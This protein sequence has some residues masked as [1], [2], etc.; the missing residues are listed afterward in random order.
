MNALTVMVIC[1]IHPV[2]HRLNLADVTAT[3][4]KLQQQRRFQGESSRIE[5]GKVLIEV[6][7]S[8]QTDEEVGE[9]QE[10]LKDGQTDDGADGVVLTRK[11]D[12][13]VREA[14]SGGDSECRN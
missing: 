14:L 3:K 13:H 2:E 9:H 4:A 6:V 8:V 10:E 1:Q 5:A 7:Q 12:E 11:E